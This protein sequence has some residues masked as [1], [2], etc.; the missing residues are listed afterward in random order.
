MEIKTEGLVLRAIDY[1]DDD[2]LLTLFSPSLGKFTAGIRGVKK[3][4]SK[5]NFAAQ[6]FA[7]CEYVLA[8]KGERYT[9]TSAYLYDG[10]FELREDVTRFYA[11]C[12]VTEVLNEVVSGEGELSS[13]FVSA[14]ETLKRLSLGQ[15]DEADALLPFFL[16]VLA[17]SGY[18]IRLNGCG[19]CGGD[20]GETAYFD[21][22]TGSFLCEECA[23][24][25]RAS[26]ST[27][28]T[29]RRAAAMPYDSE[30][31]AG[32]NKRAL[33]LIKAYLSEKTESDFP[34]FGEFIGLYN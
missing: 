6:P 18:K 21:F 5:L 16:N 1:R 26:R 7:F 8:K 12:A 20:V 33:R 34:C 25:V 10:F 22:S 4:K 31:S 29:L 13:L 15:E 3:P 11:A 9:V 27:Y 17:E 2:K 23:G 32:G 30:K 24:G 19:V 14:A 28:E